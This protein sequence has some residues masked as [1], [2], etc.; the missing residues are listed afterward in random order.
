MAV[1]KSFSGLPVKKGRVLYYSIEDDRNFVGSRLQRMVS[2]MDVSAADVTEGLV[3]RD[4]TAAN[5]PFIANYGPD[6][7]RS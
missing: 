1:G 4:M 6:G 2:R 7:Y 5:P 3:V